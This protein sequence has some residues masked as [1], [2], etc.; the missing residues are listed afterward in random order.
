[1]KLIIF[2]AISLLSSVCLA[3]N[4]PLDPNDVEG[5]DLRI[6]KEGL[7]KD[8]IRFILELNT[9]MIQVPKKHEEAITQREVFISL[10][11]KRLI[12]INNCQEGYALSYQLSFLGEALYPI[13]ID[14]A[15]QEIK[16]VGDK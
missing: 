14:I 7:S 3:C 16:G 2:L 6:V 15:V 8:E 1:M 10:S 11:E 13:L 4:N 9:K 5:K 12:D